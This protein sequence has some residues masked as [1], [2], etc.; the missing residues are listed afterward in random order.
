LNVL[1][2][3][4]RI[5]LISKTMCDWRNADNREEAYSDV[6]VRLGRGKGLIHISYLFL[7]RGRGYRSYQT[8]RLKNQT[9]KKIKNEVPLFKGKNM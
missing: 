2:E 3:F 5:Y 1:K 6:A 4:A 9:F 7:F 8:C